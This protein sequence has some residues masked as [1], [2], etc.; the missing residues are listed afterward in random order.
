MSESKTPTMQQGN[1]AAPLHNAL[2]HYDFDDQTSAPPK[3]ASGNLPPPYDNAPANNEDI[4]LEVINGIVQPP[5]IP[6]PDRPGRMTN[7]L[8]YISK[9]VFKPVWKHQFA[10][11]FQQPVDVNK[12]NL[13]DYYKII[14]NPMDLGTIKKR[15]ENNYYWSSKECI[16]DFNTM[17]TNCYI[18]NKPGE[19]VVVMAQALEKLYLTKIAQMPKDEVELDPPARKGPKGKRPVGRVGVAGAGGRGRPPSSIAGVTTVSSSMANNMSVMPPSATQSTAAAGLAGASNVMPPV[20]AQTPIM[21]ITTSSNAIAPQPGAGIPGV[22]PMAIHNSLPAQVVPPG[23]G[24]HAQAATGLETAVLGPAQVSA[25]VMTPSHIAKVKKGVKRK[26]DTTTPANAFDSSYASEPKIT[27]KVPLR[28]GRQ[29]KKPTR[30]AEDGLVP[31][32]QVSMPLMGTLGQQVATTKG[33]SKLSDNLKLCNDILK[34]M[35]GKKHALYAWP[36]YKPV[37]A[38]LL[39]LHDYHEIIKKPMDMG[40]VKNK[41]DRREYN[42]AAEF[43][44]DIRL[45]F[46]NCYKYNPP[47]HD[48]V[49]MAKKLHDVFEMRYAKIPDEPMDADD[50]KGSDSS[51]SSSESD[52]SSDSDD[53]DEERTQKLRA[54]QHNLLTMQEE[55]RK[56]VEQSG[57]KKK[58]RKKLDKSKIRSMNTKDLMMMGHNSKDLMKPVGGIRG[59]SDSVGTSLANVSLGAGH[60]LPPS[61][62]AATAAAAHY[63]ATAAVAGATKGSKATKTRGPG[64]ATATNLNKR[65]KA[66]NRSTGAKRKNAANQP[67][68]SIFD[69]EDEDNAKPMSYDEKRQL[70]LDINKLPGDKL[71]RVVTIIQSREPSLRD[72]NPDEIEIDFETLKPSTLR[73]LESYVASCLRKKP[74]KKVSGKSKDEQFAEKKQ[75]L[76]KRLQDVSG[77]LGNVK[78]PMKKD[79]SKATDAT[80]PV[81]AAASRL[82]ASSSSSS[83]SDSS[84]SSLSSSSSDSSDSETGHTGTR[85]SRKKVKKQATPSSVG[86]ASAAATATATTAIT[87]STAANLNHTAGLLMNSQATLNASG[88]ISK[89]ATSQSSNPPEQDEEGLGSVVNQPITATTASGNTSANIHT[90]AAVSIV[91]HASISVQSSRPLSL[92]NAAP[93]PKPALV[94]TTPQHNLSAQLPETPLQIG[95][96]QHHSTPQLPVASKIATS[97]TPAV[98]EAS[99]ASAIPVLQQP[100]LPVVT[101]PLVSQPIVNVSTTSSYAGMATS[102]IHHNV[103]PNVIGQTNLLHGINTSSMNKVTEK[104]NNHSSSSLVQPEKKQSTPPMLN[105]KVSPPGGTASTT[106]VKNASSWSSLAQSAS[107]KS[108]NAGNANAKDATRDTFQLFK[109]AAKE[110]QNRQR[111]LQEQQEQR[112]AQAERERAERHRLETE[113]KNEI[114]RKE[115]SISPPTNKSPPN[116]RLEF[117]KPTVLETSTP[118]TT[119]NEIAERAKLRKIE[120]EK[121]KRAA[122]AGQINITMQSDLMAEFE[123]SL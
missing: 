92:T 3:L 18:Y 89:S 108:S 26:A 55:M 59:V 45:I 79:E 84:S 106:G 91:D 52:E 94:P 99:Q 53:S 119:K 93:M 104:V 100:K 56:L 41:M 20:G 46:T 57:T 78:K 101:M 49:A 61:S 9:T 76:E 31:F 8:Q 112:R 83:D 118:P 110:K 70:S 30:Q 47:D 37:D 58:K 33:N 77:Q 75:E 51:G 36:F 43:A 34:E 13:P 32:H 102:M 38:E 29:V 14:K 4:V 73:E 1:S 107:P 116:M 88:P 111:A 66:T 98:P 21:P 39:G 40:T 44:A 117:T 122:M 90:P 63:A 12:L 15:L 121:R 81:G 68:P 80:G 86:P 105:K 27:P 87:T 22:T 96:P 28:S 85:Q 123:E 67:P 65:P 120:Q 17:F 11:P 24:Y 42:T 35:F 82:S 62:A 74:H 60:H 69:S 97:I 19:D 95:P 6:P 25:A 7:Q 109:K 72:S 50:M 114:E 115:N 103:D 113:R 54:L 10:W 5:F 2:M 48:V 64:K 16:Q 23:P 71:G